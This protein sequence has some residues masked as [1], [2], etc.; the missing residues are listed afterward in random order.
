MQVVQL[1]GRKVKL[2]GKTRTLSKCEGC[3][4]RTII[5]VKIV[6]GE[7]QV[8]CNC[9]CCQREKPEPHVRELNLY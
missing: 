7:K 3:G 9:E 2:I 1:E 4:E 6:N 5:I 8:V